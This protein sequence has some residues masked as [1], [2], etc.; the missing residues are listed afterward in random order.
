MKDLRAKYHTHEDEEAY[1]DAG[2]LAE[3]RE[4]SH[5][6]DV[7]FGMNAF[8]KRDKEGIIPEIVAD[9]YSTRKE[10]KRKMLMYKALSARLN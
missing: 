3:I 4:V 2:N 5:K 8:F 6:Y 7:A 9:I 1:L 10:A